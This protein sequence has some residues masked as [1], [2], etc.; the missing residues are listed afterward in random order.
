MYGTRGGRPGMQRR[1]GNSSQMR[2]VRA[3]FEAGVANPCLMW[4]PGWR[5]RL[6]VHGD[7]FT[8]AGPRE[9]ARCQGWH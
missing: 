2:F 8:S 9:S 3:G 5:V 4:H 1:T 6:F 7:D